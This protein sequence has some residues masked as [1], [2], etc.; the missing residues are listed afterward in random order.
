VPRTI[1]ITPR[2]L[3][4]ILMFLERF[5]LLKGVP[6]QIPAWHVAEMRHQRINASLHDRG[7]K[8]VLYLIPMVHRQVD[9]IHF[10][11]LYRPPSEASPEVVD[12]IDESGENDECQTSPQQDFRNGTHFKGLSPLYA[13]GIEQELNG[14]SRR[15]DTSRARRVIRRSG[16]RR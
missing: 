13:I 12:A 11:L 4:P 16:T 1:R 6:P 2:L 14:L 10:H 15:R 3:N 9:T 5:D 7:T 8:R